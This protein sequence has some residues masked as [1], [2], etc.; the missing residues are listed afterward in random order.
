MESESCKRRNGGEIEKCG[1]TNKYADEFHPD[2]VLP[3]DNG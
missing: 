2:P 1:G 3:R